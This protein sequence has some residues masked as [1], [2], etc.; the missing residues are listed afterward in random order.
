MELFLS[1]LVFG[2]SLVLVATLLA[3]PGLLLLLLQGSWVTEEEQA[4]QVPSSG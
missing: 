2:F 3:A 1:G 4:S